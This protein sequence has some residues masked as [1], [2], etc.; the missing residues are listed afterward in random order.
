M[1][2]FKDRLDVC[3]T[4]DGQILQVGSVCKFYKLEVLNEAISWFAKHR[5]IVYT[6]DCTEWVSIEDF[7]DN[8]SNGLDFPDYYGRNVNALSD[9]LSDLNVPDEGGLI[10]VFKRYDL[11]TE[12]FAEDAQDVLDILEDRSRNFLLMGKR[13][14]TLIQ[15]DNPSI[16]YNDVGGRSV[17]WNPKEW[18]N[19][20]RG[21]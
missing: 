18:L 6:F 2:I 13:L 10:I 5:Y 14:I 20:S 9:C 12:R 19:K 3:N 15:S 11:F 17:W 4:Y 1:A 16:T 21:L 7:H 8:I